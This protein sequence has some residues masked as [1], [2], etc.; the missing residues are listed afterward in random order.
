MLPPDGWRVSDMLQGLTKE[1]QDVRTKNNKIPIDDSC[2]FQS[3]FL[4][5]T[6]LQRT[7]SHIGSASKQVA[8]ALG[9][10]WIEMRAWCL[11]ILSLVCSSHSMP[12]SGVFK[13]E[14]PFGSPVVGM[15]LTVLASN[16]TATTD[17]H[18]IATLPVGAH[19]EFIVH[20]SKPPH[21]QDLYIFGS[22]SDATFNYTTY[23]GTRL[24]ARL[25]ALLVGVPYNTSRGYIVIGMDDLINPA[26]GLAPS[27]LIPAVGT[28]AVVDGIAGPS[29]FVFDGLRPVDGSTVTNKS[30]SFVT[31]PNAVAGVA[32]VASAVP[33]AGQRCV[34]SPG[35]SNRA[36]SVTAFPD[37]VSVVSFV[38][39]NT[40]H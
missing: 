32:G 28:A 13:I 10:N 37:A 18:G 12:V 22:A 34:V 14:S 36:Q 15:V 8:S 29:P 16:S 33:A 9:Q 35:M 17:S 23:M 27:N 38:C 30:S 40:T 20:G 4:L 2:A 31:F 24:E 19:Q 39:L 21:Y 5:L 26:A 25:L 1:Q 11:V 6:K 3:C 7:D